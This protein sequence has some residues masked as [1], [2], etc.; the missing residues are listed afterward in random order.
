VKEV[1]DTAFVT[2]KAKTLVNQQTCNGAVHHTFPPPVD[3]FAPI[4]INRIPPWAAP[5]PL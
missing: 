2:N 4:D 3:G 1:F 5:Y